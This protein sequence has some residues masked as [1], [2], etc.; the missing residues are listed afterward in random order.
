MSCMFSGRLREAWDTIED[1]MEKGYYNVKQ[2]NREETR[3][4]EAHAFNVLHLICKIADDLTDINKKDVE[5]KKKNTSFVSVSTI[6]LCNDTVE[7]Q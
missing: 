1:V 4:K 5:Q 7:T 3:Q 6:A 2:R